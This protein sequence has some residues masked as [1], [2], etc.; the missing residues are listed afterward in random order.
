M[1]CILLLLLHA[2]VIPENSPTSPKKVMISEQNKSSENPCFVFF[3]K[4]HFEHA[5]VSE[6]WNGSA[7][8]KFLSLLST[9]I[10]RAI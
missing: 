1:L 4:N 5:Q 8:L 7:I 6:T 10:T 2:T 9:D 3:I